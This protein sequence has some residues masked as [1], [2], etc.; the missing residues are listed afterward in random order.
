[1]SSKVNETAPKKSRAKLS[2][3]EENILAHQIINAAKQNDNRQ[4]MI[5]TAAYYCAE[6]RGFNGS[7]ADA[8][9]DWLEAEME[10]NNELGMFD[11]SGIDF[12]FFTHKPE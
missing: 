8:V 1:M 5:A 7:E 10:V 4:E 2:K 9:Q 3:S 11:S 12:Q 6:K